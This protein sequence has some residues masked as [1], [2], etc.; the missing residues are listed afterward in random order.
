MDLNNISTDVLIEE[1]KSRGYNTELLFSRSDVDV[2]LEDLNGDY[3]GLRLKMTDEDKDYILNNK[4]SIGW[5]TE[6]VNENI[7]DGVSD[8]FDVAIEMWEEKNKP[9]EEDDEFDVDDE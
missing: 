7:Y 1:L 8:F 4:L 3:P 2:A 6:R 9:V 5:L